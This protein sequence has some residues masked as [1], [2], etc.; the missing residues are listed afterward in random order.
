MAYSL[1][2]AAEILVLD[3]GAHPSHVHKRQ[4]FASKFQLIDSL[5]RGNK[6][7]LVRD[8]MMA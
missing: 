6:L 3:L 7:F 4:F 5:Q 2:R 8:A 1:T